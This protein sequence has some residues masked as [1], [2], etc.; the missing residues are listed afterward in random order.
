M[1]ARDAHDELPGAS[2]RTKTAQRNILK[3]GDAQERLDYN[4][5]IS[6]RILATAFLVSTTGMHAR[7]VYFDP[8][9]S[10]MT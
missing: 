8:V 5:F 3:V 1:H 9:I 10:S 4:K 2:R 6:Y 7:T